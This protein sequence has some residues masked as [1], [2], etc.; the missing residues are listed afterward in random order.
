MKEEFEFSGIVCKPSRLTGYGVG[1]FATVRLSR[2]TEG[3]KFASITQ[4]THGRCDVL[5]QIGGSFEVGTQVR[6]RGT[7]GVGALVATHVELVPFGK[8]EVVR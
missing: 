7:K 2:L 1:Q 6:G 4:N 5:S 3:F 8:L